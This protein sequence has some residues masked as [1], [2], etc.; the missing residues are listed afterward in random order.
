MIAKYGSVLFM[1]LAVGL[2]GGQVCA[3]MDSQEI[4]L[5]FAKANEA[6]RQANDLAGTG[7]A[8]DEAKK[9]YVRA[10]MHYERI[11]DEGGI[12]NAKLYYNLGNAY[13][14]N[15]DLGRAIANFRRA[16]KLDSADADIQ[17]NLAF[18]RSRRIDKVQVQTQKKVMRTLFFWHYDFSLR[19]RF[20]AG[21]VA[22]GGLFVFLT[23]LVWLSKPGLRGGLRAGAAISFMIAVCFLAS[24]GVESF[25]EA[26]QPCGVIIA[27]SVVARQGDGTNYLPSFKE[28]LHGGTE[29][30]LIEQRLGWLEIQLSDGSQGW[31]PD[32]SAEL[33]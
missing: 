26:K 3:A 23:L 7:G 30:E 14:L 15:G 22:F 2:C 13:L 19:V 18:A 11:V 17:K 5:E 8:D 24:V 28:P 21:C 25:H 4:S 32:G 1:V 6:F 16:E 27:E 31:V 9:L 20:L 10:A 33:L 12:R 29:F